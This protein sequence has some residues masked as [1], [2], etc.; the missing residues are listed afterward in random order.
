MN[1]DYQSEEA[2]PADRRARLYNVHGVILRRR[3]IGEADRVVVA[4]T[5]EHG[6][7]SFSARG[8]RKTTSKIA[9]QIEPFSLVRLHVARTRGLHIISQAEARNSYPGLRSSERAIATAGVM[10]ELLDSLT[11]EDQPNRGV[12]DLL[13]AGLTLLDAGRDPQL[14]LV[15][16]QLGLLGQLGYRPELVR[17]SVCTNELE[18]IEQGFS[19]ETGV[20]CPRCR[21][22]AP[23]VVPMSLDALKLMRVI[24]RGELS[25]L[26]GLDIDPLIVEEADHLLTAYVRQITGKSS[27][28]RDVVRELRLQ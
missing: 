26:L 23:D 5:N 1:Q 10:A 13:V 3:D 27:R 12:S 18:P 2:N 21:R 28:A 11:P 16:F 17:C 25:A 14:I 15:A 24:D 7:R 22:S 20:V 9:G 4:Y 6:K 19:L 8:S